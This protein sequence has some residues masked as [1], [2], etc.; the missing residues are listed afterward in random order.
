MNTLFDDTEHT[1]FT[2][3]LKVKMGDT[4]DSH[5]NIHFTVDKNKGMWEIDA[6]YIQAALSLWLFHIYEIQDKS[7][8]EEFGNDWLRK[9]K[10]LK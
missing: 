4:A 7:K 3:S 5:R 6:T 2:W 10:S 1:I 9:D 8:Q